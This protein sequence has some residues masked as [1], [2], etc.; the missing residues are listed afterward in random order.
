MMYSSVVSRL[1]TSFMW[2]TSRVKMSTKRAAFKSLSKA[3]ATNHDDFA[4]FRCTARGRL[5]MSQV[6]RL[7]TF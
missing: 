6:Q 3:A 1:E 2:N 4:S 5:F 7:I